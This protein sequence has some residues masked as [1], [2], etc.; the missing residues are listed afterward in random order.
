MMSATYI[1]ISKT[2]NAIKAL[3]MDELILRGVSAFSDPKWHHF[4]GQL[5]AYKLTI[6]G[7]DNGAG[8][9]LVAW[10][11]YPPFTSKFDAWFFDHLHNAKYFILQ[12]DKT[13]ALGPCAPLP[14]R[15]HHLPN[16]RYLELSNVFISQPLVDILVKVAPQ[17]ERI[18]MRDVLAHG[19]DQANVHRDWPGNNTW[20]H[21]LSSLIEA[22]PE[23][24]TD[25]D[26]RPRKWP[27][28]W[29]YLFGGAEG[30]E[31]RP[32]VNG[33][34]TKDPNRM[35]SFYGTH[36]DKYHFL[37]D[38]DVSDRNSG[39]DGATGYY[40]HLGEDQSAYDRLMKIVI[41]NQTKYNVSVS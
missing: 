39:F 15:K 2:R 13:S 23:H 34:L 32:Y 5:E 41:L 22:R 25:F 9:D 35:V 10:Y 7:G 20:A 11:R 12:P 17:L 6:P 18:V 1:A 16:L 26:V 8:L 36:Q 19:L 4:L 38:A 37:C 24:L 29:E 40:F 28:D 14:L 3:E 31:D 27:A 30:I 33:E 21:L